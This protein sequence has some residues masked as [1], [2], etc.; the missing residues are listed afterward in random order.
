MK[1]TEIYKIKKIYFFNVLMNWCSIFSVDNTCSYYEKY[2]YNKK[3]FYSLS[4]KSTVDSQTFA[5]FDTKD[6]EDA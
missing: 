4:R 3:L 6:F 2:S 5:Q 1:V